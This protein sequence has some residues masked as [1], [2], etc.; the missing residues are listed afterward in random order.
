MASE[1]SQSSGGRKTITS[2]TTT[3]TTPLRPPEQNLK[4]PR[5]DS[6]NTKFCYYNNYSLTQPRHFC[7]TCRRY[8]TKGGA[9]RNVPVGGGCRKAKKTK[10]SSGTSSS[11]RLPSDF[12]DTVTEPGAGLRFFNGQL[13]PAS[14]DFQLGVLPFSRLQSPSFNN[15]NNNNQLISFGEFS[16][17]GAS[18]SSYPFPSTVGGV[19]GETSITPSSIA[20]SIESLSSINQDLHWK[21]QQQRL[22]MLFGGEAHKD[23][24]TTHVPSLPTPLLDSQPE[25]VPPFQVQGNSNKS[26]TVLGMHIWLLL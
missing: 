17:A 18:A 8:W 14:A 21:L 24:Q 3:T 25:P 23:H 16:S 9:L 2:S 19:Y 5:C 11:S 20:S 7:K 22:A 26:C 1:D 4:C 13:A 12:S 10:S 6:P 15:N